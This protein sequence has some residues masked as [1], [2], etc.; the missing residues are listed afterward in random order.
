MDVAEFCDMTPYSLVQSIECIRFLRNANMS[1]E[2]DAS[3]TPSYSFEH[4]SMWFL[5]QKKGK[6]N[7][8]PNGNQNILSV[9]SGL[10][11][12]TWLEKANDLLTVKMYQSHTLD[13]CNMNSFSEKRPYILIATFS[14]H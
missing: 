1:E 7:S 6:W 9:I 8:E 2:P 3:G 12:R 14:W 5:T 10:Q 11:Q 4:F 13:C